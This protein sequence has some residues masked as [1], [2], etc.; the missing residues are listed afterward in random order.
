MRLSHNSRGN[1]MKKYNKSHIL[2]IVICL[3]VLL[4]FNLGCQR[5]AEQLA[6]KKTG[7][8]TPTTN[9]PTPGKTKTSTGDADQGLN[10]KTNLYISE[11]F[12]KYS[13]SIINSYRRYQSW[14]KNVE[15]GPTGK[16]SLV[17]GLYEVNGDGSD[18]ADA[19]SKAKDMEPSLPDV[20]GVS[21]K[22]IVALKEAAAQI[23]NI[24]PYYNQDDY[25]DDKFQRGKEAHPALLKAFKDFEQINKQFAVE[26]DKLEDQVAQ[27]NLELFKDN[28][29]KKFE[30]LVTDS[31]IKAKKLVKIAQYTEFSQIKAEDLQPLIDDFEKSNTEVKASGSKNAMANTYF[32]ASDDFLKAAKELMR[33]IRDKKAFDDFERRQVGTFSG[34]MVEGSPDKVIHAYNDLIQRRSFMR[35]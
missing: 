30:Y 27:Q 19:I 22:Y 11:C 26:I 32:S 15:Q 7:D 31:G 35:Y 4:A 28:P 33:R 23:K 3:G 24:Y 8:P 16:E 34:W 20:E 18:C 12:N 13:N 1:N 14:L 9:T 25:K 21:D 5:I 17:Y 6:K 2:N 10:K 29:D